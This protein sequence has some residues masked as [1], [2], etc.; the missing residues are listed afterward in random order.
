[1]ASK[2]IRYGNGELALAKKV[3]PY[4]NGALASA[5]KT[6]RYGNEQL[7]LAHKI[8]PYGN[9]NLNLTLN[10][11]NGIGIVGNGNDKI[12]LTG[13]NNILAVGNG[14]DTLSV[15]GNNNLLI[16]GD[17][18]NSVALGG[19]NETLFIGNGN[20]LINALSSSGKDVISAGNG[21]NTLN[22][23]YAH[24][25]NSMVQ[26]SAA[27]F[28]LT[29][30][31]GINSVQSLTTGSTVITL[32]DKIN[33][34]DAGVGSSVITGG[35]GADKMTYEANLNAIA[36][37]GSSTYSGG[38]G[39]DVL[40][41]KVS[42]GQLNSTDF[43]NDVLGFKAAVASGA[44]AKSFFKFS[45]IPLSVKG[46]EQIKI[47]AQDLGAPKISFTPTSVRESTA[48][49]KL[50]TLSATDIDAKDQHYWLI[51]N[52]S[53]N[54]SLKYVVGNESTQV[55]N[56]L[57]WF[58]GV[59]GPET[60]KLAAGVA[61]D[62]STPGML[63]ITVAVADIAQLQAIKAGTL[64]VSA[65]PTHTYNVPVIAVP[66]PP[67]SLRVTSP[68]G[69][70]N[71]SIP[72]N[73]SATTRYAGDVL[74]YKI[75]G[76]PAGGSL[77]AGTLNQDGSWTLT[78]A[79]I[80]GLTFK[81]GL[82]QVSGS[83]TLNV[84]ATST[85]PNGLSASI[86]QSIKVGVNPVADA[87]ILS[88]QAVSGNEN[89]A[90]PLNISA[91]LPAGDTTDVLSVKIG[92]VP[93]GATLSSGGTA[94][95]RN[96]DGTYTVNASQLKGLAITVND[97]LASATKLALAITAYSSVGNSVAT[98]KATQMVTVNPVADVP[99]LGTQVVS[100]N[101]GAA[102]P[103]NI[104]AKLP[105]GNTTDVLSVKIGNVPTGA[106]LS[107]GGTALVRNADGTYT[108]NASQL[109]G[110]AI[111]VNDQLAS[112]TKLALAITAYSSVGN[113]VATAKATQM[114]TVNPVADVPILGTQVVSGNE[115]AAIPL[116]ISAK[117]PAGNTTDV[118]SVKIGN[119][120]TG[121][122]LSSGGT[123]LVRNADGT[124]T[125]NA[126]QLKGL[127]IT[128]NDQLA[129]AT[130]LALAITAYSS[131]GNSVATAKATQ[132]VTVNP[133][134]DVPILGTQVVSGNEG[135]AIPL[136]ISAK[137]PAGNTTDVLSVKIGNVPTGAT[138][139][140][141]G[142]ALVRNADGTYT[143]NA[144][145]LKGLA[146]TVNDQLASATKLALAITAYSS[147]GNSVATAKA[148]QMVTV[149]P[150]ADVPILGTQV[151][152][153]NEGAAIPLN[154]S[155]KLP[156]G[157]TTDVLSVKIGNVP[158]GATLSS[159]GTA[160]V[161][162]ADGTYTVNASQLKGLAITVNDQLASA[163]KLALAITAYSSVGNSVAT[164]K[165]TQMVTVNPVADVPILGTQVVSGNEGAAIPL[166]ISAKLPV[167]NTT[168]VLSV[169]IGNVPTGATL[170]SGGTAL[171]RNADGTYTVNAS[172][173][174]GLAITVNDQLASA[175]KLA[176]AITA[177]SSVG[178]S[179]ATAKATQTVTVNP[180]ADVPILGTQVVSGNEGAAIPLNISAA[181]PV[182]N[183]TDVL[184]VKIGN[185][186][187]GATLSSG[188]TALVRNA[189][190][191]Y[192]V[193]ASQLKGLA[194]TV[195]D[196]LASA[197]K[198]ALA[199]TAYSSVGNSVATAKAT[200]TVT[201][202]PVADVPIL[203]TQ[204]VSGNEGAAIPLNISAALPVGNTTD[205]LS[206]K[207][208]NVP[209]GATLS[210]GGSALVANT[211]GT[212]TVSANQ[213]SDLAITVNDQLAS[214]TNLALAITAYSS[215]GNSVA[216][217]KATQTVTVNPVADVPVLGTQVVSGN[218]GAA[219][220]LN[221]SAA[222]PVGNTTDVLSVKI[223]NV[224][225]GATLSSGGS[226]LVANTDGTY[227]VSANQLSDLAI[228]VNDQL[229]STTNLALAIT[230]YSSV[231]NSVAT[232]KA[233]Q[234]VTVNPVADVPVLG[235]QVVSGNEGAAIPLNISA[236][237]PVGNTTDVLS[238]KIGNV[239]TGATLS[240]GGSALVAN[241]DGTYTVSANQLSD[242][243]ITV[244]DQLASTTNLALAITAYSSVGN[245][246]ATATST[247]TVTVNPVA[248]VPILD[249]Q[250][251]SGDVNTAIALDINAALSL[252]NTT[253]SLSVTIGNVPD[254]AILSSGGTAL[255]AN[256]DGTY[257][258]SASQLQDLAIMVSGNLTVST[259]LELAIK[260]YSTVEESVAT[261]T[262]TQLVT[263]N[264][265][266]TIDPGS[267]SSAN[268][269]T[270]A[271]GTGGSTTTVVDGS[272]L[273]GTG[274]STTTVVDGSTL[275]GTG[276]ST[277]TVVDGS[278]LTGTD[279]ST[280]T[281]VDGSTLTGTDGSTATVVDSSLAYADAGSGHDAVLV[282]RIIETV[283]PTSYTYAIDPALQGTLTGSSLDSA[284]S[285]PTIDLTPQDSILDVSA[286][287]VLSVVASDSS[288]T[289]AA[290][291][292]STVAALDS[293]NVAALD[294]STV[295]A[296][297]SS[298]VTALDSS[299][300]TVADSST[301]TVAD[302]STATV[303]D[304]LTVTAVDSTTTSAISS[305][306]T[307]DS[308]IATVDSST[309]IVSGQTDAT[310]SLQATFTD[311]GIGGV[312]VNQ[313]LI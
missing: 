4:D 113:S 68:G 205:V 164:A 75:T 270:T 137:L 71:T 139:S 249:A 121:A 198:L 153:G 72:L 82:N 252:G 220:P 180:V 161:R 99:I 163:T 177:Y 280:T 126:S 197:T 43:K 256:T 134:A 149:N 3:T 264:P 150:V 21:N 251:V 148:T 288:S 23:G 51:M 222:L 44:E 102:I 159:G 268:D 277:T 130:K 125:V 286:Q 144:S 84:I 168:D 182:G 253:D 120:P 313:T 49:A 56:G 89:T 165:A 91:K 240:S 116:N 206:V 64:Q 272:T 273:T 184:S 136:N 36:H 231:G 77:S 156:V 191:T 293:S 118:L 228:T 8:T 112:A 85:S 214:T 28:T 224:P 291:D 207:I 250:A 221:I 11:D 5:L 98:A 41:L 236:A 290:L 119:V 83:V 33:S 39:V 38:N 259:N 171:V 238:V 63:P 1:M 152:S 274:G 106:T 135:A 60:L 278:T 209:T 183:T 307:A 257:T 287:S 52:N 246:V 80:V 142:T 271:A 88:T 151:V 40:E 308:S 2:I 25:A 145:Q 300:A 199:I 233:T 258:V 169:K 58:N 54:G 26:L 101:E 97:Q 276:G 298:T 115:G 87:P 59:N 279:G 261:A 86:N 42:Y 166:N 92:N 57:T 234:T 138:L 242:L 133:V 100:G 107:S 15:L 309:A 247:Q 302:S 215:V 185:V 305:I 204:V 275:T 301:A 295:A 284:A 96:A 6:I 213:L 35:N 303:A 32:G 132:M 211:D 17:G 175:T 19:N 223:G 70:E 216:T 262:A 219:I 310:L 94:L 93:T 34:V 244:N 193:N 14:K 265:V 255:V 176:L 122:T 289:V 27:N 311:L 239:P 29:L 7:I 218:E 110:L 203:G 212:Y 269:G 181:L 55:I 103:L 167:G 174:K 127:A 105:V 299:T 281:V 73:I 292:S 243:A 267:L 263:I 282:D 104:S 31:H 254:G 78:A 62:D 225:T 154:I 111:T 296:L 245:S 12:T 143:V 109:K 173:L 74:T 155:A 22:L 260:A 217:A 160:L 226:A 30:G 195:N 128:V 65:L 304:S 227:T 285:V 124:Y 53:A 235:T 179:V 208:G 170:S 189:D 10:T 140:S 192:T 61:L 37:G 237:L 297:D 123:A 67:A 114:V 95:V 47:V 248:D 146:I 194:I 241:T 210:S 229:A 186:P 157:N 190:G 24:V 69:D 294:S 201:V 117:L 266:T 172:Q 18:N 141:G 147:V 9:G 202:N 66:V 50:G 232:A 81:S 196:Q 48:G 230:A 45:A 200:Q 188:G 76:V 46:F 158:T 79:Q 306:A 16:V 13:N 131:V 283:D 129:S 162:N 312:E 187:T 108:V 178:N 20:N 90:I